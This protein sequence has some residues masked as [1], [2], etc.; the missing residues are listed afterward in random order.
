MQLLLL[1]SSSQSHHEG[2][3]GIK[4][5]PGGIGRA[6]G[7]IPFAGCEDDSRV[8]F[9]AY[10]LKSCSYCR[11]QKKTITTELQINGSSALVK[12]IGDLNTCE[13]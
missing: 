13:T 6:G 7:S 12:L 9:C 2:T 3:L 1:L 11:I 5:R 4:Q 8:H 10:R